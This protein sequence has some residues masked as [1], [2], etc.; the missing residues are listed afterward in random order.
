MSSE[1]W[2]VLNSHTRK[3]MLL[4]ELVSSHG[5]NCF[6]PTLKI[7]PKN[8][9]ARK[10][11]PYFPGY[12]FVQLDLDNVGVSILNWMPYAHGLV[13]FDGLPASVPDELIQEIKRRVRE[14]NA[15]DKNP[16]VGIN[17]GCKVLIESGLFEGYEAIFDTRLSGSERVRVLLQLINPD[18]SIPV[19]LPIRHIKVKK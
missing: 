18:R 8:P 13:S 1:E 11:V 6:C 17:P 12:L 16:L 3:E 10:I 15:F 14:A 9:R 7:Q 4:A 19:I 5:F 2:F